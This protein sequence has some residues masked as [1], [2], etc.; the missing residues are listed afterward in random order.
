[1]GAIRGKKLVDAKAVASGSTYY[2]AWIDIGDMSRLAAFFKWSAAITGT[3]RAQTTNDKENAQQ[4]MRDMQD[5]GGLTTTAGKVAAA[6]NFYDET[7]LPPRDPA[8]GA[9]RDVM[10]HISELNAGWMRFKIA[11]TA[12]GPAN[13][14]F[15][16]NA[17]E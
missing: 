9:E 2:T 12:G 8:G 11:F 14:S 17:K 7:I 5:A 3:I 4:D 16:M 13:L 15:F 1:M 6:G 10:W